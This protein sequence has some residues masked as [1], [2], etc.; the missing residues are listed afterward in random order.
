MRCAATGASIAAATAGLL[1]AS[2]GWD[3]YLITYD[4]VKQL[5]QTSEL[6]QPLEQREAAAF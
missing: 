5:V 3:G 1:R 2:L 4:V 6:Q